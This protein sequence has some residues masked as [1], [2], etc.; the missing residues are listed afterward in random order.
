[1]PNPEPSNCARSPEGDHRSM[2]QGN[3]YVPIIGFGDKS[4]I[5]QNILLGQ[6]IWHGSASIGKVLKR[7]Y[8]FIRYR[9]RCCNIELVLRPEQSSLLLLQLISVREHK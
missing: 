4:D 7:Q 8:G 1:M 6:I 2:P 9:E 3:Y 5:P